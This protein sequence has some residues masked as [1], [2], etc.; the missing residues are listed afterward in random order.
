[1]QQIRH[2]LLVRKVPA[3]MDEQHA[4]DVVHEWAIRHNGV[5][6]SAAKHFNTCRSDAFWTLWNG[7][8]A[9]Y[10]KQLSHAR[11][12]LNFH[13]AIAVRATRGRILHR[14][15]S[16]RPQQALP[17]RILC[18]HRREEVQM[19]K[20][21]D[22]WGA[23]YVSKLRD[24]MHQSFLPGGGDTAPTWVSKVE[25][26]FG[27]ILATQFL[28]P[29]YD[30]RRKTWI[31]HPHLVA[32]TD[33]RVQWFCLNLTAVAKALGM[34]VVFEQKWPSSAALGGLHPCTGVVLPMQLRASVDDYLATHLAAQRGFGF[35][36][37]K[38]IQLPD[39]VLR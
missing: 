8:R 34:Q 31:R 33:K 24:W 12:F 7:V 22:R 38:H 13:V 9:S 5:A 32:T 28:P 27:F 35:S 18:L 6:D 37:W 4:V 14:G 39:A 17:T 36:R 25:L 29:V 16:H 20:L 1:M 11:C 3:H 10:N 19:P 23:E 2:R 30:G 21:V 15:S 26:F